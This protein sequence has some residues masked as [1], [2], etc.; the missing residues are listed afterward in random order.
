MNTETTSSRR[1]FIKRSS[2]LFAG[3]AVGGPLSVVRAAHSFG[4]DTIRLGVVGCGWRGTRAVIEALDTTTDARVQP[5]GSIRVTAMADL[6]GDR[7]QAAYRAVKGKYPHS[8]DVGPDR[9]FTGFEGFQQ[10]LQTDVD[11]VIMATPPCFR[12]LHFE[13]AVRAGK[14]VYLEAPVATD[15]P[16]VRRVLTANEGAKANGLAVAVGLRR[17]HEERYQE[18]VRRVWD[19][20][21]GNVRLARTYCN[22][23]DA[24]FRPRACGQAELEYQLRNWH[25][26]RWLSGDP[27]VE[28]HVQQLDVINWLKQGY[29]IECNGMGGQ[30]SCGSLAGKRVFDHHFVEY[31][32]ADGAKLYAQCRQA[33]HC[34]NCVA[35]FARGTC[36]A[37][38]MSG[39]KIYDSQNELVW[40]FGPGGGKGHQHEQ[41]N[42]FNALRTGVVPNEGDYGAKSTLAAIMGRMATVSGNVVTWDEAIRSN[43]AL[44]DIDRLTS[45]D[46][47]APTGHV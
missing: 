41:R 33:A 37:A 26:F 42:L 39:G 18:I 40:R 22:T 30:T 20:A 5:N 35:E 31:T 7:M 1:A 46:S 32:Y 29:P 34:W 11:V 12:P 19:G 44:A 13:A 2:L 28:K 6:F 3:G 38:D 17:H 16:G 4:S 8:V 36:G 9:R 15:A 45:L 10:L 27:M 43:Q 14:H 24:R 47:P 21:V 23:A 25:R